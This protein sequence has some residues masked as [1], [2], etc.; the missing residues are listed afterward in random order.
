MSDSLKATVID[1]ELVFTIS[2][3]G[4]LELL[5]VEP[6]VVEEEDE[7]EPPSPPAVVEPVPP[8]VEP[9]EELLLAVLGVEALPVDPT[10]TELPGERLATDTIVP[11]IGA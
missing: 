5:E 4:V 1:I 8:L 7:L 10:D 3:N 11:L 6:P 2:A 9:V